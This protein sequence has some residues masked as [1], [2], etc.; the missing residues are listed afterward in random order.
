MQTI[1]THWVID[2]IVAVIR[3]AP[4]SLKVCEVVDPFLCSN[5]LFASRF[6][7]DQTTALYGELQVIAW[8]RYQ[9][10]GCPMLF[11]GSDKIES[12][13]YANSYHI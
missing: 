8:L 4:G 7:G 3:L 11:L 12:G 9:F 5:V 1:V 6:A 10:N 13:V 2:V